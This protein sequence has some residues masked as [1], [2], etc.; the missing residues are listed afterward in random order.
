MGEDTPKLTAELIVDSAV[1]R[2]PVISPDGHWVAYVVAPTGRREERGLTTL[3]LASADGKSPSIK[4]TAGMAADSA[5]RWAQDSAS[6]FFKSDGTGSVQLRRIWLDGR[7][8]RGAD[9]EGGISA[10]LPLAAARLVA[11]LATDEP[12]EDDMRRRAERDDAMVWE[13]RYPPID[14]GC[15]ILPPESGPR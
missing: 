2:Q 4:L 8:A 10:A 15:S 12:T 3:C 14:C 11:V 7:E 13:S 6:L 1:P 5:P 9:W